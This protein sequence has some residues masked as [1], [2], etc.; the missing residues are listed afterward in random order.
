VATAV[1]FLLLAAFII[2]CA[3]ILYSIGGRVIESF[4]RSLEKLRRL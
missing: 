1:M 3:A 4:R 2:Y